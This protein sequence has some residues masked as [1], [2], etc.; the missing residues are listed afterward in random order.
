MEFSPPAPPGGMDQAATVRQ[1]HLLDDI[2][3]RLR[4]IPGV[5]SVG[6]AGAIPVA[7]GDN[8]PDGDFLVLDGRK[9]PATFEEWGELAQ[10]RAQTG[11]A[12]YAVASQGYFHTLGIPLLRG[13]VFGDQD[14]LDSP[15][16]ALISET[17]ARFRWPRQNPVGQII[18][19]G[20]M[21]GNLKPL[22]IVGV[23]GD[24]RARGLDAPPDS[25]IYVDY[26]QRGIAQNSTPTILMRTGLP[27]Q[28]IIPEARA[29]FHDLA[30]TIPVRF[31]TFSAA[32][33]GWLAE[34]RFLLL[35]VGLFAAAALLLASVGL[36]GVVSFFVMQRTQEIG[37]RMAMGAQ[38]IDVLYLVLSEAAQMTGLGL[39]VGI[40]AS[41]ALTRLVSN[42]VFGITTSDPV[43]F[44]LVAVLMSLVALFASCVPVWHAMRIDPMTALRHE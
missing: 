10:N 22:T 38:R 4:A 15:H 26:R 28:E 42:L 18:E 23:V 5:V 39:L 12:L 34:R 20:N 43:T 7:V 41:L 37:V 30:P 31:S 17:L 9:P 2:T 3:L 11:H 33:G 24:T 35:L 13:R 29:V 21:D 8:L 16:V 6:T 44:A 19:F 14:S 25:V 27:K 36:Y 32:M 40:G 1:I